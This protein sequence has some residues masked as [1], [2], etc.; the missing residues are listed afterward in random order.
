MSATRSA[1]VGTVPGLERDVGHAHDRLAREAV[2]ARA[3]ARDAQ[4]HGRGALAV[5]Q[6]AAQHAALDEVRAHGGDAL[7]VPAEGAQ[8]AGE[9]RVGRDVQQVRA[10]AQR[11]E[12]V[13]PDPARARVGGL[14]EQDA[15]ELERVPDRLVDL[16]RHL[17]AV[18]HDRAR[19]RGARRRAEQ[20]DRLLGHARGVAGEVEGEDVLPAR[21]GAQAAAVGGRI[22]AHLQVAAVGGVGDDARAGGHGLLRARRALG[23]RE[24]LA[25]AP[26][27]AGGGRAHEALVAGA[28]RCLDG[29]QQLELVLQGDG[30]RVDVVSRG[31][32]PERRRDRRQ[33]PVRRR[34]LRLGEG[35]RAR[36]RRLRAGAGDLARGGEAPAAA[37]LHAHADP[38]RA[39]AVDRIH[40]AVEDGDRLA[41]G[42][43]VAGLRVRAA[44][45]GVVHQI[46]EKLEHQKAAS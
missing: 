32:V 17:L 19:A 43:D 13:G 14:A 2:G 35:E 42:V 45:H 34:R 11:A 10:V 3:A 29:E 38:L 30:E 26:R 8:A 41:A 21:G 36:Q 7:V 37:D 5:G 46:G 20:R 16:E 9:R 12:V 27:A 4:A 23:R 31:P 18:Q 33:G 25:L 39:R 28:Q 44:P 1:S 22:G 40:A 6:R 15:V 24:R